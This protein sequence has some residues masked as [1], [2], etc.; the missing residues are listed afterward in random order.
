MVKKPTE[1]KRLGRGLAALIGDMDNE[2]VAIERARSQRR[3]P[4]EFLRP[5]PRNP[6]RDFIESDL[7]DLTKSVKEKGIMQPILCRPVEGADDS[8]EI[9]AGERR[10][11][12]AQGAGLH[13]VPVLIHNVND[14]EALELAIIENVQRADLNSLEEALGYDQLIQ[15]FDYT[16]AELADVIGKSRSHVANTM[17]LLKLPDSIKDYLKKGELTAGHA[18][19]LI[20]AND[21]EELA[22]RIV[23]DGMT[24]R[25]AEK[26][27]QEKDKEKK[28]PKPKKE[29]DADTVELERRLTDRLG[30]NVFIAPKKKG[31]ELKIQYKTLEQLDAIIS[32]L[33]K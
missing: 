6:R 31:G 24:V 23:E 15:E 19:A 33:E 10:W 14:K 16:Q 17:R 21:P 12:A 13:E 28:E 26:A 9:I 29:K 20:T 18:R 27:G 4:I 2:A 5:N 7:D 8:F 32:I 22:R 30:W 11:R 25:D 3:I 1:G